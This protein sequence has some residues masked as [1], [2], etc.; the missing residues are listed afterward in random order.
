V[1]WGNV[2]TRQRD[3]NYMVKVLNPTFQLVLTNNPQVR[4]NSYC[5]AQSEFDLKYKKSFMQTNLNEYMITKNKK[6]GDV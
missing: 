3:S 4:M 1:K 6:D 2:Y 5:A